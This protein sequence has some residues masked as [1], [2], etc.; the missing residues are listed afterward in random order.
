MLTKT[1]TPVDI[2]YKEPVKWYTKAAEQDNNKGQLLMYL[3]GLGL[4]IDQ[5]LAI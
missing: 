2:D 5:E 4:N 3:L 1:D